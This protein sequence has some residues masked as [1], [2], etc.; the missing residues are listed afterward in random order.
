VPTPIPFS[1]SPAL[2]G[3]PQGQVFNS[4]TV[5]M[6]AGYTTIFWQLDIPGTADYE[7]PN[8]HVTSQLFVNGVDAAATWNGGPGTDKQGDVDP[9]PAF[10]FDITAVP[11]GAALQVRITVT[12][13]QKFLIGIKNGLMS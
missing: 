12:A 13:P 11:A 10:A 5:S 9:P 6:A 2:R 4:P 3:L 1:V 8:N 7:N